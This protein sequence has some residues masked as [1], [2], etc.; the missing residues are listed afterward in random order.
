LRYSGFRGAHFSQLHVEE[1]QVTRGI[2]NITRMK[3]GL[4]ALQQRGELK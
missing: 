4:A 1:M 3:S 2:E